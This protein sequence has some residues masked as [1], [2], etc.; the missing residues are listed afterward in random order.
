MYLYKHSKKHLQLSLF[1]SSTIAKANW[2]IQLFTSKAI[3][4]DNFPSYRLHK[5]I[6]STLISGL[7]YLK[8][9]I[10]GPNDQKTMYVKSLVVLSLIPL[11]PTTT[12]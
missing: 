2:N 12:T 10:Q 5:Y 1:S 9:S 4:I 11:L 8:P 7:Y 3:A 6:L